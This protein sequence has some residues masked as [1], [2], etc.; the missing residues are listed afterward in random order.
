MHSF[1][2]RSCYLNNEF[3]KGDL[4]LAG[5]TVNPAAIRED[6]YVLAAQEDHITPWKGSYVTSQLLTGAN[7]HFVLSSAGH[8]AG[9]VNPP[10][11]KAWYRTGQGIHPPDPDS[12]IETTSLHQGSWWEDWIEWLGARA[13]ERVK[14]PRLGSRRHRAVGDA[15][16]TYVLEQ[17]THP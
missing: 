14:P 2:L 7:V 12:W 11:P 3:S 13:G 9:I 1:L 10:N 15:P 8:I 17:A 16:G 5:T 6:V 4:E